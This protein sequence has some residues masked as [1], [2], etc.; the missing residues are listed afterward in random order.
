M[1][2]ILIILLLL[3]LNFSAEAHMDHYKNF[4]KIEMEILRNGKVIGYNYYFFSRDGDEITVTNQVKFSIKMR[5]RKVI[6]NVI[7]HD[8]N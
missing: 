8:W 4:Q 5:C 3:I 7:I 2:K 1:K 6:P